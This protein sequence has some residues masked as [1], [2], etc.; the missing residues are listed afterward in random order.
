MQRQDFKKTDDMFNRA[1]KRAM[2]R[3]EAR[4]RAASPGVRGELE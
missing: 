2:K 4:E 3:A 1:M